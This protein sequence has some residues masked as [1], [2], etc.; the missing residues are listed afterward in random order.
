MNKLELLAYKPEK[1]VANY[2][3]S[4][5]AV[6]GRGSYGTVYLGRHVITGIILIIWLDEL[7]AIKIIDKSTMK[8]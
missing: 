8:D 4:L 5:K 6:L 7:A 1:K 2:A 3:F